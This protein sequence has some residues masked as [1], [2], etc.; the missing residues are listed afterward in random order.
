MSKIKYFK[1]QIVTLKNRETGKLV[2]K[3][4]SRDSEARRLLN[5][6]INFNFYL[7][8]TEEPYSHDEWKIVDPAETKTSNQKIGFK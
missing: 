3:R 2:T 4:L 7:E 5:G 8:G 1:G 6:N